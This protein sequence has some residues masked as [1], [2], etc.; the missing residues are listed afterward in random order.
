MM[1]LNLRI[2]MNS[3]SPKDIATTGEKVGSIPVHISYRI[4][5]LFSGHLYSNPAKAIEELVVNAYDAFAENCHVMIPDDWKADDARVVVWDDGESMDF[6]GLKDLWLV[7][8]TTK[9]S[10]ERERYA[11]GKG[12]LPIGKF[13]IGKL[14]SYVV[15]RRISHICRH[16]DEILVV[17]MDFSD[18]IPEEGTL[19][20]SEGEK[21]RPIDLPVRKLT[22]QELSELLGFLKEGKIPGTEYSLFGPDAPSSWTLVLVDGLKEDAK[23]IKTGRLRWII[24]TALPLVPDFEVSLNGVR[25]APSKE[26]NYVLNKWTV[27]LDDKVA[28]TQ[29]YES[30]SDDQETPPFDY[31]IDVPGIGRVSGELTLYEDT[32]LRGKAAEMGRS[33][34]FFIMVR[35]RLINHD[36][37]LF[38]IHQLSHAT[39]NRLHAVVH[40]DGLDDHLVASREDVGTDP[41]EAL[42]HYLV[43]KFNEIRQWYEKEHLER[44]ARRDRAMYDR[45]KDVPGPLA[46]FPLRHTVERYVHDRDIV[47]SSIRMPP[48][49]EEAVFTIEGFET[50]FLDPI[51]PLAVFDA[52]SGFVKL[53]ANHPFYLNYGD[54][55]DL[56]AFATS[57]VLLEAYLNETD[58]RQDEIRSILKKRDDLLRALVRESPYSVVVIAERIRD[59]VHQQK[60]LEEACHSGLRALGFE[61]VPM[62]GSGEPEGLASAILGVKYEDGT[63]DPSE[64]TYRL[65]YDAKSS[66]HAKVKSGNLNLASVKRHREKH[67]ADYAVVI[68]SD[69]QTS[70]GEESM[71]IMEARQEDV[72]LIQASDFA[73][74]V[75][76]SGAKPLPLNKLEGLFKEC[77]SPEES[78]EWVSKFRHEAPDRPNLGALLETIYTLQRDNP[79]DPPS[80][81]AIK[82]SDSR[83]KDVSE[84]II[85]EWIRALSRLVPDLIRIYADYVELNQTPDH[86][87]Q[88]IRQALESI[89]AEGEEPDDRPGS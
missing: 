23:L 36:D 58:L 30:G 65:T 20:W 12:R 63:G 26:D 29:G 85:K 81:G 68:A 25:V 2:P 73:N 76:L 21:P 41:K 27:G 84:R 59:T 34:G 51:E 42:Q 79:H 83:L 14:A 18:M 57:E 87:T 7:A 8:D 4:I 24:S 5:D 71:A 38:G 1:S 60:E 53:N 28:E 10:A 16:G 54:S 74:L 64:R 31:W 6:T 43:S 3:S 22:I 55:P 88:Q 39:F 72:C 19:A 44:A 82:F 35:R 47:P 89:E 49:E 50:E 13:G 69:Y 67:G 17:T 61:V 33:H 77:R 46:H 56:E 78:H 66:V 75:E 48:E 40:S 37:S 32:L 80:F 62:G 86:I 11:Q 70:Q 52:S 45:L 9:R 15:G